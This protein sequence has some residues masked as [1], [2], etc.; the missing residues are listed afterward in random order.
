LRDPCWSMLD[1]EAR[2][3]LALLWSFCLKQT[4]PTSV[5]AGS[6]AASR[7]GVLLSATETVFP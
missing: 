5:L 1:K 4:I 3:Q 7:S 6:I 2:G